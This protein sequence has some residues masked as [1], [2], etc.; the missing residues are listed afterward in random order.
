MRA[1][2]EL[3]LVTRQRI[4]GTNGLVAGPKIV[5]SRQTGPGRLFKGSSVSFAFA[6]SGADGPAA[7]ER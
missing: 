3:D 6:L 1:A 2:G 7:T 4:A 5:C